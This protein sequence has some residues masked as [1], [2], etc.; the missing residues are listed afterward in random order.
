MHDH[1]ASL[2]F[3]LPGVIR[4]PPFPPSPLLVWKQLRVGQI[5]SCDGL[6]PMFFYAVFFFAGARSPGLFSPWTERLCRKRNNW[7]GNGQCVFLVRGIN[8]QGTSCQLQ[9]D[10]IFGSE[11]EGHRCA[12][13]RIH[14]L[15]GWYSGND[16]GGRWLFWVLGDTGIGG[17]KNS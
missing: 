17:T 13:C 5:E 9:N 11:D 12:C 3:V 15:I 2:L 10:L 1:T 14:V 16:R 6:W 4:P 8:R 7:R